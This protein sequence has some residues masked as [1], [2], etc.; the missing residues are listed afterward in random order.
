LKVGLPAAAMVAGAALCRRDLPSR[1]PLPAFMVLLGD[2]SYALYLFHP[3]AMM[4]P[5]HLFGRFL[6]PAVALHFYF[7]L[8]I[9]SCIVSAIV[10]HL[11]VERPITRFLQKRIA[12]L[13]VQLD[14]GAKPAVLPA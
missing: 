4:L 12:R 10:I 5:S 6:P 8:M 2:S 7:A 3:F 1:L 9:G 14:R 11:M 13:W